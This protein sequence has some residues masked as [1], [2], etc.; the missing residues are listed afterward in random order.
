MFTNFVGPIFNKFIDGY[1]LE[2]VVESPFPGQGTFADLSLDYRSVS[3]PF[4]GD[5][6]IDFKVL[7]EFLHRPH[8]FS[9]LQ[10]CPMNPAPT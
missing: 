1:K 10:G 4:I 8:S 9:K 7:G 2:M 6:Y 5:G 3:D